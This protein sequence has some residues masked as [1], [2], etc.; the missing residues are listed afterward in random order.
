MSKIQKDIMNEFVRKVIMEG[1]LIEDDLGE[2]HHVVE[3]KKI[4]ELWS[5]TYDQL[6]KLGKYVSKKKG[7]NN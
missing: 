1:K 2:L 5:D 6:E 7:K 4:A 3:V